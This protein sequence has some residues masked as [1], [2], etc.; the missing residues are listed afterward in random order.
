MSEA[1][2]NNAEDI[3]AAFAVEPLHDK[4]ALDIYLKNHPELTDELLDL[5]LEL[6]LA[7]IGAEDEAV[8]N[9]NAV[10]DAAWALFSNPASTKST[11]TTEQFTSQVAKALS[12]L[13]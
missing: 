5:V 6:E 13:R 2:K 11:I 10:V 4:A 7:N 3:L 1:S 9:S 12:T 8:S